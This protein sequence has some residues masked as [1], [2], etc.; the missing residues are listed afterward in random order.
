MIIPT[1][2]I[3]AVFTPKDSI[4]IGGNFLHSYDIRGQLSINDIETRTHVPQRYRFPWYTR[5]HYYACSY[6][7]HVLNENPEC[8]TSFELHSL[9]HLYY[10]SLSESRTLQDTSY[11]PRERLK[12]RTETIPPT[13]NNINHL[14]RSFGKLWC[15]E[16]QS[17]RA[18]E[19]GIVHGIFDSN[20]IFEMLAMIGCKVKKKQELYGFNQSLSDA[21]YDSEVSDLECCDIHDPR[22]EAIFMDSASS[23]DDDPFT[24]IIDPLDKEWNAESGFRE[25]KNEQK[26]HVIKTETKLKSFR[27]IVAKIEKKPVQATSVFDRLKKK[28]LKKR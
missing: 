21:D 8:L 2:W 15:I 23:S 10:F 11:T 27:E 14:L 18:I 7:F 1:G 28:M 17:R 25:E 13:L 22:L 12:R 19:L 6:Y 3:H 24:I 5:I 26:S 20:S 16:M 9:G 4:V